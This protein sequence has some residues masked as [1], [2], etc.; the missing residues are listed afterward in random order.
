MTTP[1]DPRG[2]LPGPARQQFPAGSGKR[3]G[4]KGGGHGWMMIAC[5]VPMLV[6]AA[7]LLATG[8]VGVDFLIVAVMCTVMMALMMRGMGH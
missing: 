7:V 5:C 2:H 3:S 4:H 1:R 8:V 6:I